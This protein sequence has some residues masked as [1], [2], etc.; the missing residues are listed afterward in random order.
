[1]SAPY[2]LES[3]SFSVGP[4]TGITV[5]DVAVERGDVTFVVDP[6]AYPRTYQSPL[7]F[8][9]D[10][11]PNEF[12]KTCSFRPWATKGQAASA[13]V[14]VL[15]AKQRLVRSVAATLVAGRWVADTNLKR[16]QSARIAAGAVRDTWGETN[17]PAYTIA[18]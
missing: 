1:M 11:G 10:T 17:G 18:P 4:W 3:S 12:C 9:H 2:H 14:D 13:R 7:P 16:G 6:I 8:V 5:S 15:D